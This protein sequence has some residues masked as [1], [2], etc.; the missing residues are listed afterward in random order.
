LTH[1]MTAAV[2]HPSWCNK[3]DCDADDAHK[4]GWHASEAHTVQ[5]DALDSSYG[6]ALAGTPILLDKLPGVVELTQRMPAADLTDPQED[7][8]FVLSPRAAVEVGKALAAAGE[9]ALA[10]Q[11]R[12]EGPR[13]EVIFDCSP[14]GDPPGL[15]SFSQGCRSRSPLWTVRNRDRVRDPGS[16]AKTGRSAFPRPPA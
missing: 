15:A 10:S 9:R 13:V 11:P 3:T 5:D 1:A 2:E 8:C 6:I 16:G 12:G 7:V 14:V 4:S